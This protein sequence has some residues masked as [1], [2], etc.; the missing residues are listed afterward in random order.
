MTNCF[1]DKIYLINFSKNK[2]PNI[3]TKNKKI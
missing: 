3:Q 2:T 1:S